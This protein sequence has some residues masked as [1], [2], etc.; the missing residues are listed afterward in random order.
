M[1]EI[2][3]DSGHSDSDSIGTLPKPALRLVY[4]LIINFKILAP[5][6]MFSLSRTFPVRPLDSAF[7]RSGDNP[8]LLRPYF[9]ADINP[10]ADQNIGRYKDRRISP[11][12][13]GSSTDEGLVTKPSLVRV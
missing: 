7:V 5:L 12:E 13:K 3:D 4:L 10:K 1:A 11:V 6:S 8:S 9:D 2:S